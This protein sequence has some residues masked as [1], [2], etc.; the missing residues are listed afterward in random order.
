ME[1]TVT[2]EEHFEEIEKLL[3]QLESKDIS[4]EDS[5]ACYQAG[6]EHLKACNALMDQV[7][8][9]V[10]MLNGDGELEDFSEV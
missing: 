7:E 6:M 4:L 9:K 5:F 2:M 3:E 1:Q 8:K 10:Q